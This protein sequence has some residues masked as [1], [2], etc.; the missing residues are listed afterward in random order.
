V[1]A[2][3]A[4]CSRRLPPDG[5]CPC[6]ARAG[7]DVPD[8]RPFLP[9]EA[10]LGLSADDPVRPE[11]QLTATFGGG[12]T[13]ALPMGATLLRQFR[14]NLEVSWAEGIA[15]PAWNAVLIAHYRGPLSE[16]PPGTV[17]AFRSL[18]ELRDC[19]VPLFDVLAKQP[20]PELRT[21]ELHAPV[22]HAARVVATAPTFP[23]LEFLVV[24]FLEGDAGAV[25]T[26]ELLE[27]HA[28]LDCRELRV[29]TS[30]FA[31]RR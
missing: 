7:I 20:P 26:D 4:S 16:P 11:A 15:E 2:R 14:R 8:P 17:P 30:V 29:G 24:H 12:S 6:G 21:L 1:V 28:W 22:A 18:R 25:L 23:A 19:S 10:H 5:A 27:R 13:L 31:V 3:C 9:L